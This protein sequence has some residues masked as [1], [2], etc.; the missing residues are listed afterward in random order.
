[1]R[2]K[3]KRLL[4]IL[5]AFMM[6][7]SLTA[8]S[9]PSTGGDEGTTSTAYTAGTYAAEAK[10]MND[11][12]HVEVVVTDEAIESITVTQ[13]NETAGISD[14]AIAKIPE[15]IV[16]GQTLNVDTIAGATVTSTAIL[17]AVTT[18]LTEA[19]ADVEAL[20]AKEKAEA[21]VAEDVEKTADVIIVGAGGAG[22]A[23]AVS[24]TQNG[25][26]VIVIEKQSSA[27]GNT[28]VSGGIYNCPDPE[29][30][31]PEGIED[32]PEFYATQTWEGGDKVANKE[33]VD[34]LCFNAY[35]G[36]EWIQSIGIEFKDTIGQGAGA[37]YRRTHSAV[38]KA[39][40][41]Y[42]SAYLSNLEG[43]GEVIYNT[44]GQELIVE[45]GTVTGVVATGESGEKV[46]L[47]ADK[48]VIIATGGFAAN[49]DMRQEY[50]TSGKWADLGE[51]V[52]TTNPP[53]ST[54]D[55][56]AMAKAAGANL[57]DMEQIQLLYLANPNDNGAMTKYT[58]K[59]LSGTD[60]I[61]FVNP[62]GER[63][64]REDGRRDEICAGVLA[65]TDGIMY[66]VESANGSMTLPVDE[67][68]L[69]D[70]TPVLDAV[71]SGDT[72]MGETI[73]ELAA[74]IGCDPATLQATF[75]S[76][77]AAVEAKTDEFGRELYSEK[78]VDGPYFATPR[79]VGVH[80]TMG[81]IQI[82]T[83]TQVLDAE[84]NVIPGLIAC[85]EVTGGIHGANRLGGNAIVDTVV[86]GKIAGETASK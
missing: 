81:G 27:G 77:N 26:S 84:G 20:K 76:F 19:G 12:V 29:L 14:P 67:M 72:L 61:M 31:E 18:A 33:L 68:T 6:C 79:T 50:N 65:Q 62:E 51:N 16:S 22:L 80:H 71:A 2:W 63:F 78:L 44:K 34:T 47:H 5:L 53:G 56:I 46:T 69:A 74:A 60:Q 38:E 7:V 13:H 4:S 66:I 9:S 32:S 10:G 64:V 8:C 24:A 58:P 49:V 21:T 70:G 40:T 36:Y 82:N 28:I 48:N 54:G 55:G 57:V 85:G 45:D 83:E 11:Q 17:E 41:G 42:I 23:A 86:F 43:V 30:Q 52:F 35:D 37:L 59:C 73:E 75:D 3:M 1:M 25:A 15:A 39:G